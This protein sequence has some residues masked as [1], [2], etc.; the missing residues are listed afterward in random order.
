MESETER[1]RKMEEYLR[2]KGFFE[3]EKE[4]TER[5]RVLGILNNLANKF[6]SRVAH[7]HR[8]PINSNSLSK[9][10]TYGSYRLGVHSSGADIDT[11]CVVPNFITRNDFF[12]IFYDDLAQEKSITGLSKVTNTFV[13]L[14]KFKIHSIPIDLVFARLD[15]PSIP[16]N[17]DLLD[18]KFLKHMDEKCILSLNGNRVTDEILNVVPSTKTFHRALRFIKYWAQSRHLYGHAYGYMGG[19]A[20]ALCIARICQM[21]PGIDA[22][23]TVGRFFSA[24][25][26][27][28]WPQPVVIKEVPDCNF[29]LK[30]WNPKT[31]LAHR[32]DKMPVITPV[33]P[34]I[35]ST[36]NVSVST[37]TVMKRD[38]TRC[39]SICEQVAAKTVE[40]DEGLDALCAPTD[41]FTRHKNYF[42]VAVAADNSAEFAKFM[43]FAET[44]VRILASKLENIEN[45]A[46]AYVFPKTY[47][48]TSTPATNYLLRTM[49]CSGE[50]YAFGVIFI[51]IEF[52]SNKL[53]INASRK[54]NLS[55]PVSEFK[56]LLEAYEHDEECAISYEVFPLKQKLLTDI[57]ALFNEDL[58]TTTTTPTTPT[59][60]TPTTT[61]TPTSTTTTTTTP[62][63]TPKKRKIREEIRKK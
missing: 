50:S 21:F 55:R 3:E 54:M 48:T 23:E 36:H 40:I 25:A 16:S 32:N 5:E 13:P 35:C 26:K 27:W 59:P 17:I 42:A 46:F 39:A 37:L 43:G 8:I 22:F 58:P 1:E 10:F 9:I 24:F 51:G 33:Y 7:Q 44:K 4:A 45:I 34:S 20:Y 30:V 6:I 12:T 49:E 62:T 57:L 61:T 14:I 52:S 2:S 29:N 28:Q 38:F 60:T 53:P 15:I 31:N 47:T 19:V 56:T 63:P 18:N 41:F 11:L